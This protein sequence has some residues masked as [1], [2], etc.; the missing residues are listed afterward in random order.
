MPDLVMDDSG[1]AATS[2]SPRLLELRQT[3]DAMGIKWHWRNKKE[4]LEGY[5]ATCTA[6]AKEANQ[7]NPLS[8]SD[9]VAFPERV[10]EQRPIPQY[11][12]DALDYCGSYHRGNTKLIREYI[13]SIR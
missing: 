9:V 1:P 10:R 6:F 11:V 5:I 13:E 3:C 12:L 8:D 2:V 7:V 4:K